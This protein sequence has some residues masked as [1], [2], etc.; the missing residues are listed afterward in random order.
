VN[1]SAPGGISL[2]RGSEACIVGPSARPVAGPAAPYFMSWQLGT[3]GARPVVSNH[4]PLDRQGT[5]TA[6][7]LRKTTSKLTV[8]K[9]E[10]VPYVITAR[11]ASNGPVGN[12]AL[13]DTLPPGFKY[14]EGSLTV[15]TL[16]NGPVVAVKPTVVG[17][18]LTL[19]NQSFV[20]GE[21]KR[22]SMVLAVGV[23]V[24]EGQYVN[25]VVAT[26]GVGGRALSNIA[27]AAVR[28]VPDA[29]FDCTD[30]IGK[31]YDDRNAN[32]VQDDG[33]PGIPNV[34]IATVDGLLVNT[35]AEG[36]YHI[37]CAIVPK[38][39][40]GSN[41]VLKLDE[42]TLPSGY[43]VT[44]ENPAAG[45]ATRGKAL[46]VNFGATVHRVVRLDLKASAFVDGQP[47]LLPTHVPRL[48]QAVELLVER[49]SILRLA[50]EP[51]V[52]EPPELGNA[53]IA[54]LKSALLERWKA[55]GSSQ[56]RALFNLDI[57]VERVPALL[58][59]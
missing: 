26:Q 3:A 14:L 32:G 19:P 13:V 40:T 29:L 18:Q 5:G 35:D 46:K 51:A 33:E 6:I 11:N 44:T 45:R 16:A 37:A 20:P 15:Q 49:P 41:L 12:V 27:T 28:V 7:E 38:E 48:A 43:R 34:R 1:C 56:A 42:R 47:Q 4:I 58:N 52:G 8:K 21:T 57:E 59:R 31:V 23:G 9:G 22:I 50:Y 53:R 10:P 54:A 17:R 30:V 25:S 2:T 39:D 55:R 24:G 36:R